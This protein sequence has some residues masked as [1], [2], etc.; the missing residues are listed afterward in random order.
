[1]VDVHAQDAVEMS[2]IQDQQPVE[3]LGAQ[4]PDEALRDRIRL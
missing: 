3:T 4:G 2:A 1:V